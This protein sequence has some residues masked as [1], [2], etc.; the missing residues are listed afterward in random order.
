MALMRGGGES[1]V[2]PSGIRFHPA[3]QIARAALVLCGVC[4]SSAAAQTADPDAEA[5]VRWGPLSMRSTIALSNLGVD[6]NVF[7]RP[8]ATQLPGDFT[9]TFTP[10]TNLWLRLGRTWIDGNIRVDW[11]YFNRYA[12]ERGANSRYRVGVTRTLNRVRVTGGAGRASLRDRPNAEIDARS[13]MFERAFNGEVEVRAFG[14]TSLGAKTLHRKQTFDKDAVFLGASLAAELD[15]TT[16]S[17]SILVRH[18]LTPLTTLSLELGKE[19]NR[20]FSALRDADSTRL[21]GVIALQP[22]ALVNGTA[23]IGYRHFVPHNRDIPSYSG[24]TAVVNLGYRLFGTSR[25]GVQIDR[26]VQFSYD[27]NQPYYLQTGVAWTVQQQIYGPFDVLARI[28]NARMAYRDRVGAVVQVSNRVDRSRVIGGG[29]GYRLGVDKRV[30][31]TIDYVTRNAQ[32]AS[33]A[34]KGLRYGFSV[35]YER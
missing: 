31:F 25:V 5:S 12:S 7:N 10:N 3:L 19:K 27:A 20:F 8:P 29:A 24:P 35:T 17:N 28:S 11:V 22:S 9:L 33:R 32:V 4:A 6:T 18:A 23:T 26:D 15:T 14:K 16:T 2:F 34:F 1:F 21:L 30:G 13:Q